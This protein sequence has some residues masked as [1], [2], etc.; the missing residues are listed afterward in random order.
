MLGIIGWIVFGLIVGVI[1]SFLRSS[2]L[3]RA[4]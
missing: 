1:A 3:N 4:V 2:G